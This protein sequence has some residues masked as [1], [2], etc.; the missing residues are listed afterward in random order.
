MLVKKLISGK[1][2]YPMSYLNEKNNESY[3]DI[4]EDLKRDLQ[5]S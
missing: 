1:D 3:L 4:N 5:E 2:C